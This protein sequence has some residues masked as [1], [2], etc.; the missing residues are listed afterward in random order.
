MKLGFTTLA[1]FM[2]DNNKIIEL[3]KQHGFEII[4]ILGEDPFYEKD[5][6]EFKNCGIDMRIHAATVDINIASLNKGIRTESIK[7]M[8]QCGHYAESINANTITL[9]PGIIGRNEPRL[10]K[11]ALEIAV[12][13]IG[14]IID[15]TNIE[16][17]IENMPVRGKFLGNKVE[18]IEMIQEETGCSLTIDTGHGNTCGNLEEMLNL[19]NISYCHL[20]D[21]N[22]VKD[23]HITLGEGTLDLNLL[24]KIDTAIIELNNFNNILKSKKVIENL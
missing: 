9:H 1:L 2:E 20:N 7:Q 6:G 17:S 21:N 16:I 12:E 22:G 14:K 10:R 13:S 4:E 19:K 5:K 11:W 8:I 18:E 3:A 23:Q 24:K 15:N